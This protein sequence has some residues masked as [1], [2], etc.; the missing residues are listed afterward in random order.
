MVTV[1][2]FFPFSGASTKSGWTNNSS[3]WTADNGPSHTTRPNISDTRPTNSGGSSES[4]TKSARAISTGNSYMDHDFLSEL[5]LSWKI[6]FNFWLCPV[7]KPR[8]F[9][10]TQDKSTSHITLLL[11]CSQI[12]LVN[13]SCLQD[14]NWVSTHLEVRPPTDFLLSSMTYSFCL[15]YLT[16]AKIVFWSQGNLQFFSILP[17][18]SASK[19]PIIGAQVNMWPLSHLPAY[20]TKNKA[21]SPTP[22]PS[23]PAIFLCSIVYQCASTWISS[24]TTGVS[25]RSPAF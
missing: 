10:V 3:W 19:S 5:C 25:P 7:I 8:Y 1:A 12:A 9:D 20:L 6:A 14:S 23:P 2:F 22:H 21:H 17:S 16:M 13:C 4:N 24:S 11:L 15:T 18:I